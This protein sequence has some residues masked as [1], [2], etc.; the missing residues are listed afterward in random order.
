MMLQDLDVSFILRKKLDGDEFIT[1]VWSE[2]RVDAIDLIVSPLL[3]DGFVP[4]S[5]V[6]GCNFP[7]REFEAW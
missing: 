4:V 6:V 5:T 7:T 1:P 3:E 2:R